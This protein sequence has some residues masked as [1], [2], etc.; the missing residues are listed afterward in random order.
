[1][2]A[3]SHNLGRRGFLKTLARAAV[4]GGVSAL[5]GGCNSQ[6]TPA[7]LGNLPE[8][9]VAPSV[10]VD[11]NRY[12]YVGPDG[13]LVA[14]VD[15]YWYRTHPDY[16]VFEPTDPLLFVHLEMG[17]VYSPYM[18]EQGEL[19]LVPWRDGRRGPPPPP[20]GY[21]PYPPRDFG[22]VGPDAR[23]RRHQD[24]GYPRD[25]RDRN[26]PRWDDY[27]KYEQ[28]DRRERGPER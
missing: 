7:S 2:D 24:G 17:V 21:R 5:L 26:V 13:Q 28:R 10:P 23:V 8:P 9:P 22:R 27:R 1:M 15:P 18:N 25:A 12:Y 6:N 14:Q 20:L 19:F 16:Y 4:V 11:A 3:S